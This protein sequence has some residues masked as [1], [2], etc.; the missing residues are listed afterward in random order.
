MPILEFDNLSK[1]FGGVDAL[2]DVSFSVEAGQIHAVVG[3]NGAGK[4]TLMKCLVG[5]HRADRGTI[6]F[7]GA[8]IAPS[9]P[10]AARL[11]G[12]DVVFQEIELA[13]NLTVAQSIFLAREPTRLGFIDRAQIRAQASMALDRVGLPVS[14][15]APIEGLRTAEK[16]GV[17]IARALAH[18]ARV[19]IMD[20]PTSSLSDHEVE[21]LMTVLESLRAEGTTILYVSHKLE[22]IFRLADTVTV[23]RDG[24]HIATKPRADLDTDALISLMAGPDRAADPALDPAASSA[25]TTK[26]PDLRTSEPVV[27][28]A[29]GL[30]NGK[31]FAQ[32]SFELHRGEVLGLF[33][34]VGAG[35]TEL[36][37]AIFG[38]DPI[39]AGELRL[40]GELVRFRSAASAIAKGLALVPEDRKLQGLLLDENLRRNISLPAMSE[41]AVAGVISRT[42]EYA[43]AGD[44]VLRFGIVARSGV[45]QVAQSLS[46]GNQQKV[47]LAKWLATNPRVLILDEP[48][49]G[50][51]VGAKREVHEMIRRF[52][53]SGLAVLLISSEL[54]EVMI[55]SDRIMIMRGG[56]IAATVSAAGST[57]DALLKLAVHG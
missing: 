35:R 11:L 57:R 17:Q 31:D 15:D 12:I 23:L 21:R 25:A 5:V 26:R 47:V 43:L 13:A 2:T 52:A 54:E 48:T 44:A 56:R 19:L 20:E 27:L 24:R 16:Q 39:S 46:G 41:V 29:S 6:R 28:S 34:I 32:V 50:I 8:V 55:L 45:D 51:D 4:S 53:V 3:E 22:E 14:P 9:S 33:G 40:D 10:E 1:H 38:L 30:G 18:G 37:R 36:S 49:K 7:N 42:K